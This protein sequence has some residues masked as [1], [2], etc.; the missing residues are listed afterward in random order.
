MLL[1]EEDA[2]TVLAIG[3]P[4]HAWVSGQLARAWGNEALGVLEPREELCLAADQHDIG[5]A[6]YDLAPRLDPDTGLP[7]PFNRMPYPTHLD[8]WELAPRRLLTQCRYAALLVSMHGEALYRL[9][10]LD[11]MEAGE[12]E[13]IRGYLAG[14][15]ALQAD[16]ADALGADP[17]QLARNQRLL[18]TWDFLSLA[19]CLRW[20]PCAT[21]ETPTAGAPAPLALEP[22]AGAEDR[23]TLAPWPFAADRV[24]LRTE[25]RRLHGRF[26]DEPTLHAAL[27]AAEGVAL[28]FE[29]APA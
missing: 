1:R 19:V 6:L 9:R 23:F 17:A 15:R 27:A 18:W 5:M 29:L 16:L 22:V 13:R 20:A 26:G 24:V 4:A 12:A 7:Y 2:G 14:Q 28:R 8:L 10:D 3:Q 25:G 21:P 11:A